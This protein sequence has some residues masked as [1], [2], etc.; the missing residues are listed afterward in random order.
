[1]G[2]GPQTNSG[3]EE[4]LSRSRVVL[5]G[6]LSEEKIISLIRLGGE[7]EPLD[8]KRSYDL[9]GKKVTK[10]ELEIVAEVVAMANTSGATSCWAWT[11]TA[12]G[13]RRRTG[14]TASPRNSLAA[15]SSPGGTRR[16]P[17][18][19]ARWPRPRPF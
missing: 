9:T 16:A 14:R 1:M 2:D 17:S 12:T 4:I 3:D 15:V 11:R 7:E 10:D 8:Y 13:P 6:D 5:D 19:C 18:R